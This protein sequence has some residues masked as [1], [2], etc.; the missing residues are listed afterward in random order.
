MTADKPIDVR[1]YLLVFGALL[2]LTVVTV[3]I[4][5]VH[6]APGPAILIGLAIASVKAALV[7][8]FFMHLKGEKALSYGLL[9]LAAFFVLFLF[10]LPFLDMRWIEPLQAHAAPASGLSAAPAPEAPVHAVP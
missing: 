7:A 1:P 6:L 5:Y 4:S 9:G 2:V 10:L 3:L 8:A